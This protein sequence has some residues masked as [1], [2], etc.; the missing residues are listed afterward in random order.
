MANNIRPI[1]DSPMDN[2]PD[3][4]A[5]PEGDNEILPDQLLQP[6]ADIA[7]EGLQN[8]RGAEPGDEYKKDKD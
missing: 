2:E 7:V 3:S 5:T 6:S 1:P 8:P 4:V